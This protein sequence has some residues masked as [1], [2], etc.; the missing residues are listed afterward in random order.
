VTEHEIKAYEKRKK[1]KRKPR[2]S[3]AHIPGLHQIVRKPDLPGYT[4]LQRSS[5]ENAIEAGTFPKPISLGCRS[6]GWLASELA[7]WQRQRIA[8]RDQGTADRSGL[9]GRAAKLRRTVRSV[10]P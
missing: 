4:G 9:A 8:E 5:I 2:P 7:E 3:V 1:R 6:V 10:Q